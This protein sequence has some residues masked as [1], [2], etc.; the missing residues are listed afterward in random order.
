MTLKCPVCSALVWLSLSVAC[1]AGM[2]QNPWS[3]LAH[4]TAWVLLGDVNED[5]VWQTQLR[6]VNVTQGDQF[7][8]LPIR[9]DVLEVIEPIDLV[10][11]GY[12][13]NGERDRLLF[14]GDRAVSKNDLVGSRLP[15]GSRVAVQEVRVEQPVS[16][17]AGVWVRVVPKEARR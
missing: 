4:S 17:L 6:H 1:A 2:A 14:P 10:I 5:R 9:G 3:R 12:G 7:T 11:L 13:T 16:G 8:G 15:P